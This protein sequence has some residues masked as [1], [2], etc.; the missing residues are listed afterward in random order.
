M[1]DEIFGF[2]AAMNL[3]NAEQYTLAGKNNIIMSSI[4]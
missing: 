3:V 2:M 4:Q 1:F